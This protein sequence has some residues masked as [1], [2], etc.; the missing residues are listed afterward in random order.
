[1]L[2]AVLQ[3]ARCK[4]DIDKTV[5]IQLKHSVKK[6]RLQRLLCVF[7]KRLDDFG[8]ETVFLLLCVF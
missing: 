6:K 4:C 7:I 1:M 5:C 2:S 8:E 3:G